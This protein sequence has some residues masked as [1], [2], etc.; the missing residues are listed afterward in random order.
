MGVPE[1]DPSDERV[2]TVARRVIATPGG[3]LTGELAS[4]R[5][6]PSRMP[7]DRLCIGAVNPD[8]PARVL[9]LGAVR[10]RFIYK[11]SK[12]RFLCETSFC[13]R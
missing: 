12:D 9:E 6:L 2:R 13:F 3:P 7:S 4:F 10:C 11:V 5:L 8:M 1:S